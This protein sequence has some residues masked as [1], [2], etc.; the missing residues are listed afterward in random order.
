[1]RV[2]GGSRLAAPRRTS[3]GSRL[4]DLRGCRIAAL[5]DVPGCPISREVA[6]VLMGAVDAAQAA[7]AAV[8]H[9]DTPIDLEAARSI[10]VRLAGA[11]LALDP[12]QGEPGPGSDPL[13]QAMRMSHREW[14]IL[15]QERREIARQWDT[16]MHNYDLVLCPVA[17]TAATPHD[18]HTTSSRRVDVDGVMRPEVEGNVWNVVTCG[19]L[20]PATAV[21]AGVTADGLP[22]GV[23]MVG[24]MGDDLTM[25]RL[26]EQIGDR[27]AA[28][29]P[30]PGF[31]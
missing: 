2:L 28:P 18:D 26:A 24:R 29:N 25:L 6:A 15:D 9:P 31:E 22:V 11:A 13:E 23:M 16:F 27:L 17:A 12:L 1:M 10:S 20:L 7:G 30:P 21:P 14:L 8:D 4:L 5:I 3:D 19:L